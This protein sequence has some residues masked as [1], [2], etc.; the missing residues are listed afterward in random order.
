MCLGG[1]LK[2]KVNAW[3]KATFGILEAKINHWEDALEQLEMK[4]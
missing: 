1:F 3:G 4:E 2:E